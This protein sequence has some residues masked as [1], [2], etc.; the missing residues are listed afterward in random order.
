MSDNVERHPDSGLP[1]IEAGGQ[2]RVLGCLP[3]A[4]SPASALGAASPLWGAERT[5]PP[6]KWREC[7]YHADW[8]VVNTDDQ[9]ATQSCVGHVIES[10]FTY[11]WLQAGQK[12]KLFSPTYVYGLINHGVDR[13]ANL[14]D[15]FNAL[16]LFG[17]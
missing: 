16:K 14:S 1:M 2:Y 12:Y 5:L 6:E 13:G 15:G 11:A 17:I 4:H 9:G 7:N 3:P 10:V 8:P